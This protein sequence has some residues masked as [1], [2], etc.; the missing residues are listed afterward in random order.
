MMCRGDV[1]GCYQLINFTRECPQ[2][3]LELHQC[4]DNCNAVISR[5]N[6]V[7]REVEP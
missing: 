4:H 5:D 3:A 6:A 7:M 1:H 2:H